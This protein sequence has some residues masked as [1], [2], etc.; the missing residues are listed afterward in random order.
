MA[1]YLIQSE[2]LDDIA[3][4][5]NAKTGGSSAMTPAEMVT[6]IGSI[7]GKPPFPVPA[8]SAL[9]LFQAKGLYYDSDV[10]FDFGDAVLNGTEMF[11]NA[12]VRSGSGKIKIT[13]KNICGNNGIGSAPLQLAYNGTFQT[14]ELDT[15]ESV[16]YPQRCASRNVKYFTGTPM[17]LV[18]APNSGYGYD[19]Y[20]IVEIR[21]LE[22]TATGDCYLNGGNL[23]DES[24][25]SVANALTATSAT[26]TLAAAKKTRLSNILGRVESVTADGETYDRFVADASG[27]VSLMSFITNTKGWTVA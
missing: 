23:S 22:N 1:E 17:K 2:T 15:I 5:I 4:A 6:A 25:V 8:T 19:T 20:S 16:L 24:L 21:F 9:P 10:H 11:M 27:A 14:L 12:T 18:S 26:L 7:S 3:D 13:A